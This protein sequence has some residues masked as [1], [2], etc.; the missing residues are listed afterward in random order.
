MLAININN[1]IVEQYFR[2]NPKEASDLLEAIATNKI[3]LVAPRKKDETDKLKELQA[4]IN[5]NNT[6]NIKTAT[7]IN[8]SALTDGIND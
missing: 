7:D 1:P 2:H 4:L 8:I 5:F 3:A 6:L